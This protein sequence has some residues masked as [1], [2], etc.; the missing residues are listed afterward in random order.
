MFVSIDLGGTKTRVASSKNLTELFEIEKFSTNENLDAQKKLLN[1][2]I[3]SVSHS[4]KV[5]GI[6]I[7]VPA[8]LDRKEGKYKHLTNFHELDGYEYGEILDT[9]LR[10]ALYIVENDAALAG[11]AEAVSG[12]GRDFPVVAYIT[13]STGVGGVRIADEELPH[14][15]KFSEPG[16]HII[17]PEGRYHES[18]GQNGCWEAYVSG[19]A[20]EEI[21]GRSPIDCTDENIWEDYAY[22]LSRGV[23]NLISFWAPDVIVFG[24]GM[25]NNYDFFSDPLVRHL[26]SQKFFDIPEI[27]KSEYMDN[28]GVTGGFIALSRA[29]NFGSVL[30]GF[31]EV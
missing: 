2:S 23:I 24:G 3:I 5:L 27:R 22:R 29:D 9:T 17:E 4:E 20:F 13:L 18:C 6:S 8:I 30:D 31:G 7:G 11:L 19:D 26:N 10:E 1:E 25:S 14:G 28:A 15:F 21:Y 16:H 12:A